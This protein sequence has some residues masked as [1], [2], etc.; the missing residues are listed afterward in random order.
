MNTMTTEK[1]QTT[2]PRH[3][4]TLRVHLEFID[5]MA[6]SVCIAGTFNDWRPEATLM[7][8][9]GAGRW[10]KDLSLPPGTYEYRLVVDGEW[11]PDPQASEKITNSF[12]GCNSLLKVAPPASPKS[13]LQTHQPSVALP[14]HA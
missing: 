12:G 4:K 8:H 2:P 9:L 10:V 7:V 3:R 14:D 1:S 11:K 5:P 13:S 6:E